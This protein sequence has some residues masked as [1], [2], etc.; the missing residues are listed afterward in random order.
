MISLYP[1]QKI[2]GVFAGIY[3]VLLVLIFSIKG[4]SISIGTAFKY[5]GIY[6][7]I[8]FILLSFLWKYIWKKIPILNEWI[9]PDLNGNWNV[10]IYWKRDDILGIKKGI[11][12]IKQDFLKLSM[13]LFT[14]ES[15]SET[16]VVQPKKHPESGRLHLYYIYRNTPKSNTQLDPHIG[17][18]LLKLSPNNMSELEGNYFTD[19]NTKGVLKFTRQDSL[20]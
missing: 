20:T 6:E 19:R 16:L 13:E 12:N 9:F 8:I 15:E 1:L 3:T 10:E 2:I 11:V 17:S 18:A 7:L 14:D 4:E 5:A